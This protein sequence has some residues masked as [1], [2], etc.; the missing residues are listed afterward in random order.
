MRLGRH[1]VHVSEDVRGFGCLCL[2]M[3]LGG[4]HVHVFEDV[5]G[6]ECLCLFVRLGGHHVHVFEDVR[7]F[8]N[9]SLGRFR[10]HGI[11]VLEDVVVGEII[12]GQDRR[13]IGCLLGS[14]CDRR[15]SSRGIERLGAQADVGVFDELG[16][17][18]QLGQR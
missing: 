3:R 9:G 17:E 18:H 2:L 15:R 5:R 16:I 14:G 1:H 8:G 10:R 13:G 4:H 7:G 12:A 11:H 6:F